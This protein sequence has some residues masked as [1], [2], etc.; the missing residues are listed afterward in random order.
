MYKI[1][2]VEDDTITNFINTNKLNSLGL[3]D[4]DTVENGALAV[5]YLKNT[6]ADL[7]FLDLNMPVMDGFEFLKYKKENNICPNSPVIILTS[8][9]RASDKEKVNEFDNIIDYLEK[10]LSYD[11]IKQILLKIE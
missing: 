6:C 4:V 3:K 1:L 5:D 11:K 9:I 7:I 10:P 2:L 8:S